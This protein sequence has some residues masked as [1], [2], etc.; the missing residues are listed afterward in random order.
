LENKVSENRRLEQAVRSSGIAKSARF[1]VPEPF[2]P[3]KNTLNQRA[4]C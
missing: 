3:T 2:W 1:E 4:G